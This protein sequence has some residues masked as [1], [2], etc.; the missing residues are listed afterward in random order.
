MD[1]A[2]RQMTMADYDD[3][4]SLWDVAEG[5]CLDE[6]DRREAI[7]RYLRR[8]RGLCFVATANGRLVGTALCGHEGRKGTLR[9]LVVAPDWRGKGV[10]GTLVKE[11]LSALAHEGIGKCNTFVL[12][13][14]PEG[15]Q[16]WEHL[17]WLVHEDNFR[18]LHIRTKPEEAI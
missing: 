14:N 13:S 15:R 4:Y 1:Y 16:F 18:L 7:E 8:N 9:H 12:N 5:I 3:A 6:D 17:G 11:C 10:G 2:I